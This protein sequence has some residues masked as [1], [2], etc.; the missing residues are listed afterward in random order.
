MASRRP[1]LASSSIIRPA[2]V[3]EAEHFRPF[4]E[5]LASR[6]IPGRAETLVV[7]PI[8]RKI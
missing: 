6:I 4:V 8:P 5:R 1:A 2:R 3:P 7:S